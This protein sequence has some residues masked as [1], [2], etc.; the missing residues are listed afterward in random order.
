MEEKTMKIREVI[1]NLN[2]LA[3]VIRK[4]IQMPY[5]LR[6]AIRKNYKVLVEEYS[7]YE[8]E[9]NK[10]KKRLNEGANEQ[11]VEK[12]L[13]NILELEVNVD[14]IKVSESVMESVTCSPSDEMLLQFMLI[15]D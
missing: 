5:E 12:E 3:K 14:I 9:R 10:L 11:E 15:E 2:N 1:A 7:L 6:R 13:E 8:E 4:E